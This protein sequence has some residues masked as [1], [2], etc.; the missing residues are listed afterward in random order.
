[1]L[2][3][4]YVSTIAPV[5]D[6]KKILDEIVSQSLIKNKALA[7][8]GVLLFTGVHFAQAIEGRKAVVYSLFSSICADNRHLSI[9]LVDKPEIKRRA[10]ASWSLAYCGTASYVDRPIQSYLNGSYRG[11][12]FAEH[13]LRLMVA[14]ADGSD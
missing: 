10:F 3:I 7:V 9:H 13:L 2:R 1:M 8:T 6:Q 11:D 5:E 4:L 14:F 12:L